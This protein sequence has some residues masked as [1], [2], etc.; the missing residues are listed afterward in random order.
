MFAGRRQEG[1]E[2]STV[3]FAFCDA[4]LNAF[5]KFEDSQHISECSYLQTDA[6]FVISESFE[7]IVFL[8]LLLH[9]CGLKLRLEV[10][11]NVLS[12]V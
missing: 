1:C 9:S 2:A 6:E 7:V 5:C 3:C 11:C 4:D 10:G 8:K 12:P